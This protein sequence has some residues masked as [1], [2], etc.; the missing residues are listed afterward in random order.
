MD[1]HRMGFFTTQ[2]QLDA[3]MGQGRSRGEGPSNPAGSSFLPGLWPSVTTASQDG[4]GT[5]EGRKFVASLLWLV[6]RAVG[7]VLS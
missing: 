2:G 5:L 7:P 4:L 1:R 3:K 6:G